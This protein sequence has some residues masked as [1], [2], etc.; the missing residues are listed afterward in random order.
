MSVRILR[1]LSNLLVLAGL[2]LFAAT[3]T[4]SCSANRATP[5][6]EPTLSPQPATLPPV[7]GYPQ[8]VATVRHASGATSEFVEGFLL[9]RPRTSDDLQRFVARY[10]GEIV[11]DNSVPALPAA[12]GVTLT[13]A[14]RAPTEYLVRIDLSRVD[15]SRFGTLAARAGW[16]GVVEFSSDAGLR[17]FTGALDARDQGF[18][19]DANFVFQEQQAFPAAPAGLP[20]TLLSSN[21]RPSAP[22]VFTDALTQPLYGAAPNGSPANVTLAWQ[23]V[24]A[25]GIQRQVRVAIIDDGYYLTTTGQPLGADSDFAGVPLQIDLVRGTPFADGAGAGVCGGTPCPWHGTGAAGVAVG[26]LNNNQGVAGT[27][28]VIAVPILVKAGRT[29]ANKNQAIRA[30]VAAG[31][32][33][34]SMSWGI[35]CDSVRCREADRDDTPFDDLAGSANRPVFVASAGNGQNGNGYEVAAPSF[36]HPCIEDH[37]ICVGALNTGAANATDRIQYSNFGDR[38]DVFA[39]T[40]IPVMSYPN[41]TGVVGV[42]TFGG[43]SASAPYVAGIAAMMK[44]LDPSLGSDQIG[45]ILRQTAIPGTGD[46]KRV[47]DAFAAVRRVAQPFPMVKDRHEPNSLEKSPTD[48]GSAAGYVENNLNLDASDRDF[49]R[50]GVPGGSIATITLRYPSRLG[51]VSIA[52]LTGA[53]GACAAPAFV[54][55]TPRADGTGRDLV[56]RLAGGPHVIETRANA[57]VSY[58]LSMAFTLPAIAPDSYEPN[59]LVS[60]AKFQQSTVIR[61]TSGPQGVLVEG[62]SPR[63]TLEATIHAPSDVDYYIVQGVDL[64]GKT[65]TLT[66][67]SI[68]FNTPAVMVYGNDSN[69]D[70]Q[71]F[72]LN[73][74]KTAGALVA[75]QTGTACVSD[76]LAVTLDQNVMYLVRVAGAPGRYTLQNGITTSDHRLPFKQR[77]RVYEVLHPGEPIESVVR[78]PEVYIVPADRAFESATS[79]DPRIHLRLLDV[80]G[81]VIAQGAPSGT[82]ESISVSN[83]GDTT[84]LLEATRRDESADAPTLHLAWRPAGGR[85]MPA[86]P[87]SPNVNAPQR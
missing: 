30:A 68:I 77:D 36:F 14:Q 19:A 13:D 41:A 32:D 73:A 84:M 29:R 6:V 46:A 2:T 12:F 83:G 66:G 47:V 34:V 27:G 48:L 44:A 37:V 55:D 65:F 24:A 71:V 40:N 67:T 52:S 35:D 43:T 33:V 58:N 5:R 72:R 62:F 31:A 26:V 20:L 78:G 63:V 21:E 50:F 3:T 1:H 51:T 57:L 10:G 42:R 45:T 86:S 64:T 28:S 85:A 11:Q 69:V 79:D 38:V 15:V 70:L 9:I 80:G 56:Y 23:F 74:N 7:K 75:H 53:G 81:R 87:V 8:P 16:Q 39:P 49:F 25:H 17:T 4:T 59:D 18:R 54:S 76:P 22:G 82:G 61:H 60:Q